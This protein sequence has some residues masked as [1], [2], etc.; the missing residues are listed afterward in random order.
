MN[1]LNRLNSIATKF[2][3]EDSG[4]DLLEFAIAGGFIAASAV[5]AMKDLRSDILNAVHSI[6]GSVTTDF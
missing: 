1:R 4:V 6:C 3:V 5:L 2:L